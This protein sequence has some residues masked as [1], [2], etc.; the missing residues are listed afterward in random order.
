MTEKLESLLR[1]ATLE[2][3]P[4]RVSDAVFAEIRREASR[5]RRNRL[6]FR[7][8]R[9]SAAMLAVLAAAA[10]IHGLAG[11]RAAADDAGVADAGDIALDIIGFATPCGF[12]A[13][14]AE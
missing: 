4:A 13:E 1:A 11:S 3:P 10:A 7:W 6:L 2:R 9:N 14:D 12:Y 5:R 8:A